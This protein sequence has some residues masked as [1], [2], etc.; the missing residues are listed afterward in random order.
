MSPAAARGT[1]PSPTTR[2]S[3]GRGSRKSRPFPPDSDKDG[4]EHTWP[5]SAVAAQAR[6][7]SETPGAIH[8]SR[9]SGV[10]LPVTCL[11]QPALKL[12]PEASGSGA[13]EQASPLGFGRPTEACQRGQS[14]RWARLQPAEGQRESP[15]N[16]RGLEVQRKGSWHLRSSVGVLHRGRD[17]P[18]TQRSETRRTYDLMLPLSLSKLAVVW[19]SVLAK[20]TQGSR[21]RHPRAA[22]R[23]RRSGWVG[24]GAPRRPSLTT[25][26]VRVLSTRSDYSSP[27]F[28]TFPESRSR[29]CKTVAG[30]PEQR[31]QRGRT[32]EATLGSMIIGSWKS[33]CP[34]QHPVGH[35]S[36]VQWEGRLGAWPWG[37]GPWAVLFILQSGRSSVRVVK[38]PQ[39]QGPASAAPAQLA[40]N[41][42]PRGSQASKSNQRPAGNP[43]ASSSKP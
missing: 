6:T 2:G 4:P 12:R 43:S 10:L 7:A 31:T 24:R 18:R 8:C 26:P 13:G 27:P 9:H 42:N 5:T 34:F 23:V 25:A 15:L 41:D 3:T 20:V 14:S 30:F 22:G 19:L 21:S 36:A 28:Q 29:P 33:G 39:C 38:P 32:A 40:L 11:I 35:R 1:E 17:H 37:W 16:T